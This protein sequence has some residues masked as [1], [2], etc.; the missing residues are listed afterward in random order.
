MQEGGM[1]TTT[2]SQQSS[3]MNR[4]IPP[5]KTAGKSVT[6]NK[7]LSM[8]YNANEAQGGEQPSGGSKNMENNSEVSSK[9]NNQSNLANNPNAGK[10]FVE[11]HLGKERSINQ[12]AGKGNCGDH[13][14]MHKGA[15]GKQRSNNLEQTKD[16]NHTKNRSSSTGTSGD[17]EHDKDHTPKANNN[18]TGKLAPNA[19]NQ[20]D[21]NKSRNLLN[22]EK[23]NEHEKGIH[24]AQADGNRQ[25]VVRTNKGNTTMDPRISP[26][27]KVSSNF[28][29]YRPNHPKTNQFSPENNQNRPHFNNSGNKNTN[30]QIPEPSPPTVVQSLATRLRANQAKNTNHVIITPPPIM[31][32]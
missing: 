2:S 14:Q 23:Q 4:S 6:I 5:T 20:H 27:I 17:S 30:S 24:N 19:H 18:I 1:T 3:S 25:N 31:A 13:D 29:T 21:H 8:N 32:T 22:S 15:N 10:V 28:D 16:P 11:S 26:P 12:I 7:A 9:C